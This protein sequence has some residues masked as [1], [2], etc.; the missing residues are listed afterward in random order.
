MSDVL[1]LLTDFG[2]RDGYV[3]AVKGVLLKLAPRAVLVD[4]GHE[5]PPGN[6]A[7]A[8]FALRQAAP[9]GPA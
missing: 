2:T 1:T 8:S 6:I 7:A 4:I 5:I 9:R 3:G